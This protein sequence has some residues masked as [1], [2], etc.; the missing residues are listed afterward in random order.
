MISKEHQLVFEISPIRDI[1][2]L[3][4]R[5]RG[6]QRQRKRRAPVYPSNLHLAKKMVLSEMDMQ[7]HSA[8]DGTIT[9][10]PIINDYIILSGEKLL[11]F[12]KF[13]TRVKIRLK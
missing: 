2:D 13:A 6:G 7:K 8:R 12:F 5:Q 4:S 3:R 1:S 10:I 11:L 9:T